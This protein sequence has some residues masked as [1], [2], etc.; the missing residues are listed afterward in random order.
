MKKILLSA[1]LLVT[2]LT[3]CKKSEQQANCTYAEC[4]IVAPAAEIQNVQA[5]LTS[6]NLTAQQHCSGMFY[7]IENQGSGR[8]ATS[9]SYVT[10]RYRGTYFNGNVLDAP[11]DPVSFDLTQVIRGWTVGVPLIREGGRIVLYIPPSLAYG[12]NDYRNP[13][14]GQVLVPGNSYLI[15]EIDLVAVQR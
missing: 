4:G 11:P 12:P 8:T 1:Y 7:R 13:Q 2:F 10:A 14:T 9:C 6:N 3:G 15:F 5:H